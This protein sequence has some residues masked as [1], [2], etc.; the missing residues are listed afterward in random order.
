MKYSAEAGQSIINSPNR[1]SLIHPRWQKPSSIAILMDLHS[2]RRYVSPLI[3]YKLSYYT[4]AF[5]I[6][7]FQDF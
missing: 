4:L 7:R 5:E 6:P 3:A 2:W 1:V